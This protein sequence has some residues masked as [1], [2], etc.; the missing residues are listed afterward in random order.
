[1]SEPSR[2]T[3]PSR[4]E[5]L[6]EL[7][8]DLWW[9]WNPVA[10]EVFRRLDYKLWRQTNHNPVKM[11]GLVSP[12]R[13]AEVERDPSF[14]HVYDDAM[15]RLADARSGSGT[16]WSRCH[17][18]LSDTRVA[19]F[20]AE[21]AIHQSIPVYAGGLGVLAGDYCKEASDLGVPLIGVGF[22]YSR[23]YFHQ[24]ISAEGWQVESYD[25]FRIEETPLERARTSAGEPC[26]VLVPVGH[27]NI[28]VAVCLVRLGRVKV[29]LLDTDMEENPPSDRE[30]SARLYV[31]GHE[32]RLQQEIILGIGGVRALRALGHNP[33][34][35]HLNEGHASFVVFERIRE[36]VDAGETVMGALEKVRST[37]V[38]TT[39]TP[40]PAGHDAF[41]FHL[42]D[43]Q[44][45]GCWETDGD[46]RNSLLSLGGYD[47]GAGWLFN[48]TVLA[49]RGSSAVNGVS[50][51]HREVTRKMFASVWTDTKEPIQGITNGIHVPTWI[52]PAIDALLERHLGSDWK[53]RQDDA[54]VW[55]GIFAIPDE[56]LW[57]ARQS[58]K[59]YLLTFVREHARHRWT[60][61]QVTA[62]HLAASG[63][64]LD[65]S[66]LTI[67][68]ARRFTEYK[69]PELIF[70]DQDRLARLLNA[71]RPVQL[72]F[73]GKAHP[74]DEPGKRSI[75]RICHLAGD[76]RFAGRIAFVDDYDLHVAHFFVQG[77]DVWL[78]TPRKPIEACGTSGM[79]A[80][81]NGVPHLSVG[82]GWWA[83]GCTGLNGWLIEPGESRDEHSEAQAIYR[84]LEEEVIPAFYERDKRGVP[85]RWM[86]IVKQAI[87]TVAPRFCARRMLKDYV[88]QMYV[89]R[90]E[91]A[92]QALASLQEGRPSSDG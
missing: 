49:L 11:L 66:A 77:C 86:A 6:P 22:R 73:A 26:T 5:R 20:S 80:S 30:L 55:D 81:I 83:E 16:W 19:Y 46:R 68:Y 4:I 57:E 23:G 39:H 72:I 25:R 41:P 38:F 84:L 32:S 48:M 36:L 69:R 54:S 8:S 40:L 92:K 15:E 12:Q 9:S 44:L 24:T 53:E 35:W 52:A 91:G 75:Q 50:E 18:N 28:H 63:T 76:P 60:R 33:T 45:A 2:Q 21:F 78:N 88:E 47:N 42:V 87:R 70:N 65:P 13:L 82:N 58:L 90:A 79:K 67:G 61:Q 56:E 64:L 1:M 17:T 10:R 27:T 74:S 14:V 43:R 29:Y 31:A 7:A 51:V 85:V 3:L 34:V 37:T 89:P 71:S 59:A 62:A